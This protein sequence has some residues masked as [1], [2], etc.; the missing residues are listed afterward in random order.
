M[1]PKTFWDNSPSVQ[2]GAS[3]AERPRFDSRSVDGGAGQEGIE[4]AVAPVG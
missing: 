4:A 2:A 3:P 1:F